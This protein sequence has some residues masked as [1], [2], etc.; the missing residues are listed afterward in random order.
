MKKSLWALA[1]LAVSSAVCAQNQTQL[2]KEDLLSAFAQYNPA[3]LEKAAQDSSYN[4]VLQQL[5]AS[6]AVPRTVAHSYELIGLVKNFDYSVRL[7]AL[8]K[9]YKQELTLQDMSGQALPAWEKNALGELT[10][11][12]QGIYQ[13]S[14][15]VRKQ[16]LKDYKKQLKQVRRDTQLSVEQRT[17]EQSKLQEQIKQLKQEIRNFKRQPKQ[18]VAEAARYYL[19][20]IQAG[21]I[22][23]QKSALAAEQSVSHDIKANHK[24]PVAE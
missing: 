14:L 19:T 2:G 23:G 5:I 20:Q 24:K 6:Y 12:M 4:E 1:L 22:A 17:Q 13:N 18:T 3:A 15:W 10:P 9:K 21:Y 11:V 7:Q 8:E 16:E